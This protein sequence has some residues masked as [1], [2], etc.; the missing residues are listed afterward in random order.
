MM[1]TPRKGTAMNEMSAADQDWADAPEHSSM[2][3]T[4]YGAKMRAK[5]V[6]L[7]KGF[8]GKVRRFAGI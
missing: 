3:N 7:G 2:G 1:E 6:A 5:K 8:V 4:E